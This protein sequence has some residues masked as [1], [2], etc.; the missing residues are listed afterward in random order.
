[1]FPV[2]LFLNKL[3]KPPATTW[4]RR[5]RWSCCFWSAWSLSRTFGGISGNANYVYFPFRHSSR[6][7]HQ[8][9]RFSSPRIFGSLSSFLLNACLCHGRHR[10]EGGDQRESFEHVEFADEAEWRWI[11]GSVP[12]TQTQHGEQSVNCGSSDRSLGML[13]FG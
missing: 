13:G 8:T 4:A 9:A 10:P 12:T 2:S 3:S 1:M 6:L 7:T 11:Y 5:H